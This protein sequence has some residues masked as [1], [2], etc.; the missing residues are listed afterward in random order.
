MDPKRIASLA[1]LMQATK[2]D[3]HR[4]GALLAA[5]A[6]VDEIATPQANERGYRDGTWTAPAQRIEYILKVAEWLLKP[7]GRLLPPPPD[8]PVRFC[9]WCDIPASPSAA[10]HPNRQTEHVVPRETP[11][12]P[13]TDNPQV[14]R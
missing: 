9:N 14:A 10:N 8:V 13:V 11:P 6:F 2:I 5:A 7:A 12:W 3:E 1:E 4:G